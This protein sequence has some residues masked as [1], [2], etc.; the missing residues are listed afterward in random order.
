MM[1][2][3]TGTI[4]KNLKTKQIMQEIKNDKMIN[5]VLFALLILILIFFVVDKWKK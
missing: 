2:D 1:Y 4:N 5:W 3:K